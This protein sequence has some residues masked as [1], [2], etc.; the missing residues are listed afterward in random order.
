[1]AAMTA[2]PLSDKI[3]YVVSLVPDQGFEDKFNNWYDNEHVP[4]LL[5][6][7]GFNEARRFQLVDGQSGSPD[8]LAI[9]DVSTMDAF[10]SEPY[11]RQRNRPPSEM[12]ALARE[13]AEHRSWLLGAKYREILHCT[14]S[15]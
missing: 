5:S 4:E 12:T 7:P 8:Y 6:C 3:L 14:R 1:M 10:N 2:M 11:Q 13:V 15:E 9:Y